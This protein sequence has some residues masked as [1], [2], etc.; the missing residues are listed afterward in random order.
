MP[1]DT[2]PPSPSAG[3]VLKDVQTGKLPIGSVEEIL[4]KAPDDLVEE[5]VEIPEWGCSVRLRSF[6]AATSARIKQ[7]GFTTRG[8]ETTVAWAAMEQ[9]QFKEGCIEPKFTDDQVKK[10]HLTSG[11]GFAR[12]I[13]WLDE[14]SK[15]N[16]EELKKARDEFPGPDESEEV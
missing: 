6:T 15:I 11:R 14:K 7:R 9:L 10:L 13:E 2:T 12:V 8:E 4:K 3:E 1:G 16:K 5:V